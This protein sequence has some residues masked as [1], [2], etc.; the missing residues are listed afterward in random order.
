VLS[1]EN[2]VFEYP[3][4]ED[5]F[6]TMLRTRTCVGLV[7]TVDAQIVGFVVYLLQRDALAI[8]NLAVHPD[9]QRQG[10]GA[11][12]VQRLI[13]NKLVPDRRNSLTAPVRER[14]LDAQLFFRH[15]NFRAIGIL[16]EHYSDSDTDED[17]YLFKFHRRG[18]GE[19]GRPLKKG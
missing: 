7:A 16:H 5:D 11:A 15:L 3:W 17:A 6:L 18:P 13:D 12:L 9:W 2:A 1:I 19:R 14:N 4:T 8:E 10:I